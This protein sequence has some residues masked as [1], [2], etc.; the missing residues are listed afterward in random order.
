MKGIYFKSE[1][2]LTSHFLITVDV[3]QE[4]HHSLVHIYDMSLPQEYLKN[5][6]IVDDSQL[7]SKLLCTLDIWN[8][9]YFPTFNNDNN[10]WYHNMDGKEDR[11]GAVADVLKFAKK[12]GIERGEIDLY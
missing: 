6:H 9:Y 8:K 4:G 12:L 11:I 3:K 1:K 7:D 5:G 2:D 10:Q